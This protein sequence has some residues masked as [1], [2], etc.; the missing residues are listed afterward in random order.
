MATN[1]ECIIGDIPTIFGSGSIPTN[2][3]RGR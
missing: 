1:V 2:K 3:K